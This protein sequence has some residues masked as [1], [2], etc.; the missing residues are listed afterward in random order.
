MEG[1][2]PGTR[3]DITGH[4]NGTFLTIT[5][6]DNG[7]G[8]EHDRLRVI[9]DS[10]AADAQRFPDGFPVRTGIGI[11]NVHGRLRKRFGPPSGLVITSEPGGGT[12]VDLTIAITGDSSWSV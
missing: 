12:R 6:L 9:C 2:E 5:V 11:L 1:A 7:T 4:R 3:L 8:M 10:L